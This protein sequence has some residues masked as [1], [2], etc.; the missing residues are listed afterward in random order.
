MSF[1]DKHRDR[2]ASRPLADTPPRPD[3]LPGEFPCLEEMLLVDTMP[4]GSTR[5]TSTLLVFSDDGVLKCCLIDNELSLKAFMT[6]GSLS[7]LLTT[8][9]VALCDDCVDW[10]ADTKKKRR[11]R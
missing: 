2:V 7:D 1:L 9:E 5:A 11:R 3:S 4:D 10:R 6:A 8:V